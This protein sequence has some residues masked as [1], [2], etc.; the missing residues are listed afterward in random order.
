MA[1]R[2]ILDLDGSPR[3]TKSTSKSKTTPNTSI[4]MMGVK[5]KN[6]WPFSENRDSP[7]SLQTMGYLRAEFVPPPQTRSSLK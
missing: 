6:Q 5:K 4:V 1:L 7:I 2:P 3:T